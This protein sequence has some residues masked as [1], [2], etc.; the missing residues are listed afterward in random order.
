M[1]HLDRL[2]T[3]WVQ[4]L[5]VLMPRS[6]A[7]WMVMLGID[8]CQPATE[9]DATK[10][11]NIAKGVATESDRKVTFTRYA[12][13]HGEPSMQH[14]QSY[15][16]KVTF[17]SEPLDFD[18]E[19][20]A[21]NWALT[22]EG[23]DLVRMAQ[24][25]PHIE[26]TSYEA[27]QSKA[28][29]DEMERRRTWRPIRTSHGV[30]TATELDRLHEI[31]KLYG[32]QLSSERDGDEKKRFDQ[33]MKTLVGELLQARVFVVHDDRPRDTYGYPINEWSPA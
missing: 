12:A 31:A 30:I 26:D 11:A 7:D 5:E 21:Q 13:K 29:R 25:F 4:R 1:A 28:A 9:A 15:G 33:G 8:G 17:F 32:A 20:Q 3:R 16:C 10:L 22:A 14:W 18:L 24:F 6:G 2:E 27:H 23:G 19:H